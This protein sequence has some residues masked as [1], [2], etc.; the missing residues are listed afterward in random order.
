MRG[1]RLFIVAAIAAL[2]AGP[3]FAGQALSPERQ[4]DSDALRALAAATPALPMDR[5]ELNFAK[6]ECEYRP[7]KSDGSLD[8]P[9]KTGYNLKSNTAV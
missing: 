7:Q 3:A 5:V 9:V 4:A 6:I 1:L 2:A 8:N